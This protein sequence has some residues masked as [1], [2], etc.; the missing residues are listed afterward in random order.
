MGT[1]KGLVVSNAVDHSVAPVIMT[2]KY[3][4]FFFPCFI[5]CRLQVGGPWS[6]VDGRWSGGTR[7]EAARRGRASVVVG[8][9]GK[10]GTGRS[11][12]CPRRVLLGREKDGKKEGKQDITLP[13]TNL[14]PPT[15]TTQ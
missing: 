7:R 15:H 13:K 12:R 4:V 14:D 1:V 10:G 6:M 5:G 11:S 8:E 3:P 2:K 9:A